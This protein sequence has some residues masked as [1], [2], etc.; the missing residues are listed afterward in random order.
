[1]FNP[2][3]PAKLP[4]Q[5]KNTGTRLLNKSPNQQSSKVPAAKPLGENK[6][7]NSA[8]SEKMQQKLK[9][10]LVKPRPDQIRPQLDQ[11]RPQLEQDDQLTSEYSNTEERYPARNRL[12]EASYQQQPQVK[13]SCLIFHICSK[14]LFHFLML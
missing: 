8:I 2:Q 3:I 7:E 6:V 10:D 5:I 13:T 11:V 14:L 9:L 1:M 4:E 12:L